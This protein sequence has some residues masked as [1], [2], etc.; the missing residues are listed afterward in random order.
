MIEA[1]WSKIVEWFVAMAWPQIKDLLV[2]VLWEIIRWLIKRFPDVFDMWR[3]KQEFEYQAR[4]QAASQEAKEAS[5]PI[6]AARKDGEARAWREAL[7]E[8]RKEVEPL[9]EELQLVL[10]QGGLHAEAAVAGLKVEDVFQ[11]LKEGE[12]KISSAPLS[13]LAPGPSVHPVPGCSEVCSVCGKY[14]GTKVKNGIRFC[15]YCLPK[16]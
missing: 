14:A 3:K 12:L 9:K 4:A 8:L 6:S 10:E 13:L 1:V 2:K 7:D 16:K 15:V 5:D 11:G